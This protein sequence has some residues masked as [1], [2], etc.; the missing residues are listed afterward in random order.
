LEARATT[1]AL[2]Y[3]ALQAIAHIAR[4]RHDTGS[5]ESQE[6]SRKFAQA[7]G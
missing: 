4:L 1:A 5:K 7:S 3:D 2:R 6:S